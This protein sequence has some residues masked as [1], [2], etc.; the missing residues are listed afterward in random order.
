LKRK[1]VVCICNSKGGTGKTTIA[2]ILAQMGVEA[3]LNV[4]ICDLDPQQDFLDLMQSWECRIL[5]DIKEV[6]AAKEDEGIDLIIID[7]P[8]TKSVEDEAVLNSDLVL[9]PVSHSMRALVSATDAAE[10]CSIGVV[11]NLPDPKSKFER[12]IVE[13]AEKHCYIYA[14]VQQYERI[15]ENITMGKSWYTGLTEKQMTP[16]L[17]F[18]DKLAED[19]SS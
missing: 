17:S 1:K 6:V 5:K 10:K 3:D 11:L 18:M 8:P 2:T 9:V 4:A 7:T 19:I 13:T 16:Y 12:Q 15:R 14:S